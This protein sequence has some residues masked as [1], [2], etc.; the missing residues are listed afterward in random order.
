[1]LY[2]GKV[3]A[4]IA[5]PVTSWVAASYGNV[6][7][8]I[9]PTTGNTVQT[10]PSLGGLAVDMFVRPSDNLLYAHLTNGNVVVVNPALNTIVATYT[11]YQTVVLPQ[12][13]GYSRLC[14]NSADTHLY[15][16]SQGVVQVL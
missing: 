16:S 15:V 12:E 2:S 1:L 14:F 11:G 5:D 9:D 13:G 6:I 3:G 4:I 10:S 7:Y 8:W